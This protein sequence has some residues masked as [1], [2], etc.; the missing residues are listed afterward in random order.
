MFD[1]CIVPRARA[2]A[3]GVHNTA[4]QTSPYVQGSWSR[5]LR[6]RSCAKVR[7]RD[8]DAYACCSQCLWL[9]SAR[10]TGLAALAPPLT[11]RQK[12]SQEQRMLALSS[13]LH[14]P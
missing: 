5:P 6:H 11:L 4:V 2:I 3:P 13:L 12:L 9:S 10:R 1:C 8:P 7:P 14:L